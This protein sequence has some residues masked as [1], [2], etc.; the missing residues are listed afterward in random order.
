MATKAIAA[1]EIRT[2]KV[3]ARVLAHLLRCEFLPTV[4]QP[5]AETRRHRQLSGRRAS[6]V[7]EGQRR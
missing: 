6:L 3:D 4:S 1:S 5:D 7:G 2:D